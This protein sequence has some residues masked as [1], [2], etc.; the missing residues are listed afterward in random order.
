MKYKVLKKC[1]GFRGRLWK[2]VGEIVDIDPSE[3][4]PTQFQPLG[5]IKPVEVKPIDPRAPVEVEP[6][7]TLKM[8]GGFG[9]TLET[10]KLG[11]VL[12]T[13][14]VPNKRVPRKKKGAGSVKKSD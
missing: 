4:P 12:T 8:R 11:R 1:A 10:V 6:G 13:D 9:S 14:K 3:N 7:K 2:N 5:E